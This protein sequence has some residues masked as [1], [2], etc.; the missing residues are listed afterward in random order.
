MALEIDA[1]PLRQAVQLLKQG[2]FEVTSSSH[3]ALTAHKDVVVTNTG[4][5]SEQPD[6]VSFGLKNDSD[7]SEPF[8]DAQV[9]RCNSPK[10]EGHVVVYATWQAS[11]KEPVQTGLVL[12][13]KASTP[14][15][16]ERLTRAL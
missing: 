5:S 10:L 16:A 12:V 1:T 6:R 8:L 9:C 14:D 15:A 7:E 3:P 13:L 4:Y 11:Q 2:G